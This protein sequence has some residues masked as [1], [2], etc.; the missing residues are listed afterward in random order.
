MGGEAGACVMGGGKAEGRVSVGD[1]PG[2]PA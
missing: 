2:M 1:A